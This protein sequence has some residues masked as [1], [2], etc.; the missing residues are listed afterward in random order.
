MRH[1][2]PFIVAKISSP[3][4]PLL[5]YADTDG[6]GLVALDFPGSKPVAGIAMVAPEKHP[7]LK[8]AARALR[9]YFDKQAPLPRGLSAVRGGTAFQRK[10]WKAIARIPFGKVKTYGEIAREI[11]SPNAARAVGAACGANPLPLFVPCHR[12]VASNGALGGFSGGLGIKKKLLRLENVTL[13]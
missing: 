8:A 4:G 10:V 9:D 6:K 5:A 12:V 1:V 11:G 13:L 3:L 2:D 7:A